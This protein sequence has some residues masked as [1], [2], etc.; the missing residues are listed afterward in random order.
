MV[1]SFVLRNYFAS[2]CLSGFAV[3]ILFDIALSAWQW[4]KEKLVMIAAIGVGDLEQSVHFGVGA[5]ALAIGLLCA[6]GSACIS[7]KP[8]LSGKL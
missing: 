4:R 8:G 1:V 7:W 3:G 2:A 6:V 5:F